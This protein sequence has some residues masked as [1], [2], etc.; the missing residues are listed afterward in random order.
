MKIG[1]KGVSEGERERGRERGRERERKGG[2]HTFL[3]SSLVM[4]LPISDGIETASMRNPNLIAQIDK[5]GGTVS[6]VRRPA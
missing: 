4:E 2:R 3:E 5:C 6:E 1:R